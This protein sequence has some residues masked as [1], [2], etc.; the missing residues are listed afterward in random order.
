MA[1]CAA[2]WARAIG[3]EHLAAFLF[4]RDFAERSIR[5]E[6]IRAILGDK[7]QALEM[8]YLPISPYISLNLP[9]V[10]PDR[11]VS[12]CD[13]GGQ[14]QRRLHEDGRDP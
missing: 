10:R 14:L 1:G 13:L 8:G 7:V 6:Q 3:R 12:R 2:M 11:A 5:G 4:W 9:D